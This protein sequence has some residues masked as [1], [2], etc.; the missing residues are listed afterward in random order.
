MAPKHKN[1]NYILIGGVIGFLLGICGNLVATWIQVDVI[2]N[3]FSPLRIGLI[4]LCSLTGIFIMA[5]LESKMD[6]LVAKE[7]STNR[8]NENSYSKIRLVWSKL[9]TKGKD[10][11][12]DEVSAIGSD[13]DIDTK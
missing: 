8:K 5:N 3:S 12:M 13:I 6:G 4:I 2:K 11:K 9:K 10:I 7:K 1:K